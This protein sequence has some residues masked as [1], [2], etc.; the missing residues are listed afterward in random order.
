MESGVRPQLAEAA[1]QTR[2]VAARDALE[3]VGWVSFGWLS[4][5]YLLIAGYYA[6]RYRLRGHVQSAFIAALTTGWI[7]AGAAVSGILSRTLGLALT[8]AGGAFGTVF[9]ITLVDEL[10]RGALRKRK[11]AP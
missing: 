4:A 5:V 3:L 2:A 6:L 11:E 9:L 1:A 7:L 10:R 8:L